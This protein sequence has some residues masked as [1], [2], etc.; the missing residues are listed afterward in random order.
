MNY[1]IRQIR[2]MIIVFVVVLFVIALTF[3]GASH[4]GSP[5]IG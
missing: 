2:L 5:P 1:D 4:G 3:L